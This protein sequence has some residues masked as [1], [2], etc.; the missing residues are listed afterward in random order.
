V[1]YYAKATSVAAHKLSEMSIDL[2]QNLDHLDRQQTKQRL[3]EILQAGRYIEQASARELQ[4]NE[5]LSTGIRVTTQVTEQLVSGA[6][7]ANEAA[8]QLEEVIGQL[9]QVVGE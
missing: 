3:N 8:A 7:S 4:S 2:M 6:K 5:S 9:R 1:Q